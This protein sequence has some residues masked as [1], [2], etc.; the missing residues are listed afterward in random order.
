[1]IS[2]QTITNRALINHIVTVMIALPGV[3]YF[4]IQTSYS[5]STEIKITGTNTYINGKK[6]SSQISVDQLSKLLSTSYKKDT[7]GKVSM[8]G[9]NYLFED[10]GIYVTYKRCK[11]GPPRLWYMMISLDKP[12]NDEDIYRITKQSFSGTIHFNDYQWDFTKSL[13]NYHAI[14]ETGWIE[15][16]SKIPGMHMQNNSVTSYLFKY[17]N[18][19]VT[20]NCEPDHKLTSVWLPVISH[21]CR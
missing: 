16:V 5:Q 3:L 12:K 1:M 14:M 20:F 8:A 10:A 9:I 11:S 4:F 18:R 13:E 19:P 15:E 17:G 6:I 21:P 2:Y 7:E